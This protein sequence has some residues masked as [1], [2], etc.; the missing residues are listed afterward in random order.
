MGQT[1]KS[2]QFFKIFM[3]QIWKSATLLPQS[4]CASPAETKPGVRVLTG[5]PMNN[6]CQEEGSGARTCGPGSGQ[7]EG[8]GG[9]RCML[10]TSGAGG[11]LLQ[12]SVL[13]R[14]IDFGAGRAF[15]RP[16]ATTKCFSRGANCSLCM[17]SW[18]RGMEFNNVL[19]FTW[20]LV[21]Y[22]IKI[23]DRLCGT[24]CDNYNIPAMEL[25]SNAAHM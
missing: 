25:G 21:R 14:T 7:C 2:K 8:R 3:K 22:S 23:I 20:M 5:R 9:W 16:P 4:G 15:L 18:S 11:P 10:I 6:R 12:V 17:I 1:I 13:Q 24:V 19:F